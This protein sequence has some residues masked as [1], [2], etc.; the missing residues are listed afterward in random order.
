MILSIDI[1]ISRN[2]FI[3][4]KRKYDFTHTRSD[5]KYC[6]ILPKKLKGTFS[7][8]P[9]SLLILLNISPHLFLLLLNISP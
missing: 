6:Y 1:S 5:Y 7:V 3:L 4:Y 2:V 9:K 8:Q